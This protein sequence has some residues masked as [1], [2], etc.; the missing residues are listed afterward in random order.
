MTFKKKKK[1]DRSLD[2]QLIGYQSP[3]DGHRISSFQLFNLLI[4]LV[5][6]GAGSVK[7]STSEDTGISELKGHLQ[8]HAW[9]TS[10]LITL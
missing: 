8:S 4:D 7:V 1:K 10:L 6:L 9:G 3:R 2:G 5:Q